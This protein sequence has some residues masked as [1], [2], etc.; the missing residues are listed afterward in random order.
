MNILYLI[1]N[2]FDI[3]L[4]MKTKY[5]D[6]YEFYCGAKSDGELIIDLKNNIGKGIHNWA[7]LEIALGRYTEKLKS[8]EEF[9][10]VYEDIGEKLSQ[11]LEK[12]A[13]E[14]DIS[15]VDKN[16]FYSHIV[17][18]EK[19]LPQ[20]DRNKIKSLIKDKWGAQNWFVQLLT[21]NYT[22]TI[23]KIVGEFRQ[24]YKIGE[25]H[26]GAFLL[27]RIEHIHGYTDDS[28]VL[29][30][31]DISQISNKSFHQNEDIVEALV[32]PNCNQALRHTIDEQCID[33]VLNANIICIF[34]SSI[35]DTD[36]LWWDLVGECLK[37]DCIL[38]IYDVCEKID[39]STRYKMNRKERELKSRFLSKTS[40]KEEEKEAVKDNI[41]IALNTGM[42]CLL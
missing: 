30:V 18:P 7:D 36:R 16:V 26:S 6:F 34:G 29:G 38:I 5:S 15:K 20:R 9:D 21:F 31:N 4:G 27:S 40:L 12:E 28:R 14:Y 1:G 23:E 22:R 32:K 10:I 24:N 19:F 37:R 11:Y 33:L 25:N 2:G 41:F 3:N 8:Q 17:Y 13:E 39:P 42:F 35:G